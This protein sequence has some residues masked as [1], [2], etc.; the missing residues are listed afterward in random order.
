MATIAD[1]N[2]NDLVFDY[3][4]FNSAISAI[5]GSISDI[6][7]DGGQTYIPV[8]YLPLD[9]QNLSKTQTPCFT[10]DIYEL[11]FEPAMDNWQIYNQSSVVIE[12]NTYTSGH[13]AKAE[14]ITL[15]SEIIKKLIAVQDSGD[16]RFLGMNVDENNFVNTI[17][18]DVTRG[19]VRLSC[20][21]DNHNKV[22]TKRRY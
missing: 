9:T 2:I 4:G 6:S 5:L 22:I 7:L 3:N 17:I 16:Y 18:T 20:V 14:N 1:G 15:R 12:L 11:P 13:H 10:V 19:I 8:T 21:V